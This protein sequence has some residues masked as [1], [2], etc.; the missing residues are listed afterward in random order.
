M[1]RFTALAAAIIL[2][3]SF[4]TSCAKDDGIP[5]GMK[6]AS[7]TDEP[8]KLYVPEEMT[9]N[10][11]SGISSAFGYI[12]EKFII[13]ARY[14]TP[15]DTDMTLEQYMQ[16]CAEGYADSLDTFE[17]KSTD[18]A[19]LSGVDSLKMSYTAKIDGI[20][21]TCTQISVKHKGDMVSLNFYLPTASV[22]DENIQ[23]INNIASAFVLC[24]KPEPVNDEMVDKNTP[25]G[26]KIASGDK[27][28]YRLYVPKNWICSSESGK[29]EAYYP[30]SE[31]SNVTVTSFSPDGEMSAADYIAECEEKYAESIKGYTFI[32]KTDTKVAQKDAISLVFGA[33]YDNINFK[34]MQVTFVFN[35]MV[36]SITYTSTAEQFDSHLEDVEKIISEF[37]FR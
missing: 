15:A 21:Y 13:S 4:L 8:F 32:E 23:V 3:L 35:G 7:R 27:L 11:D 6:L 12:P 9:I 16:Y 25:Q 22:N 10:T 28:E 30:E 33:N 20:D 31:K 24:D 1:K 14:F 37:T 5:D 34:I 19:V 18:A 36:Y 2:C 17:W 26:M 29:S